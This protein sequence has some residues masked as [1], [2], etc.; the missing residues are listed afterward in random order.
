M[1]KIAWLRVIIL[2]VWGAVALASSLAPML[3][4]TPW[5]ELRDGLLPNLGTEM[6]GAALT[7]ALFERYIGRGER[8]EEKK[9]SL[10]AQ[11]GSSVKDVA[12][13]AAEELERHGWLYDGSLR[14]ASLLGADLRGAFLVRADLSKAGLAGANLRGANLRGANLRGCFLDGAD[15]SGAN[16]TGADLSE[17]FLSRANLRGANLAEANLTGADLIGANLRGADLAGADL[18]GADLREATVTEEQL[19]QARSLKGAILP[20]GTEHV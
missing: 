15:L 9:A 11:M 13:A 4:G 8:Q 17:V 10:I 12:I 14:R 20:D 16:L 2:L 3:W 18:A 19:A 7:Y 1:K 5:N 6:I